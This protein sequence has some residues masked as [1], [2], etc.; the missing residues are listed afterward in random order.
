MQQTIFGFF[1]SAEEASHAVE[2]LRESGFNATDIDLSTSHTTGGEADSP[3]AVSDESRYSQSGTDLSE[4]RTLNEDLIQDR[5]DDNDYQSGDSIGRFFRHL[6]DNKEDVERFANAGRRNCI[7]SVHAETTALAE[8]A[9]D[10]LDDCGAVDIDEEMDDATSAGKN[11][12]A[13]TDTLDETEKINMERR[14]K[15]GADGLTPV[16]GSETENVQDEANDRERRRSRIVERRVND[17]LR[18]REPSSAQSASRN[19]SSRDELSGN[20]SSG[21]SDKTDDLREEKR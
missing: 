16:S 11:T 17:D 6:F 21:F 8:H 3:Y 20:D 7:V 19:E 2:R 1:N 12:G 18:L 10:I 4:R 15:F 14:S 9:R 13:Y 5:K